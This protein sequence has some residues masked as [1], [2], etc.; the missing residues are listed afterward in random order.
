MKIYLKYDF[1][2]SQLFSVWWSVWAERVLLDLNIFSQRSQGIDTLSKCCDSMCCWMFILCP[3]FWHT[4]QMYVFR[5]PSFVRRPVFSIIDL[6]LSSS[7]CMFPMPLFDK[8]TILST[9]SSAIFLYPHLVLT[10]W[11]LLQELKLLQMDLVSQLFHSARFFVQSVLWAEIGQQVQEMIQDF[12]ERHLSLQCIE[13]QWWL[14]ALQTSHLSWRSVDERASSFSASPWRKDSMQPRS[15]CVLPPAHHPRWP[16]WH[17]LS[18]FHL[19]NFQRQCWD[20][21]WSHSTEDRVSQTFVGTDWITV[22]C[23]PDTVH[24]GEKS[25]IE[26]NENTFCKSGSSF[27]DLRWSAKSLINRVSHS[28]REKAAKRHLLFDG[29]CN[30]ILEYHL[31]PLHLVFRPLRSIINLKL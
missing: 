2:S 13:N 12:P 31:I 25:R 18:Q 28:K 22:D 23:W 1:F 24:C 30:L 5:L 27:C 11:L 10:S 29:A 21:L 26:C 4:L 14:Q 16:G 7:S 8:A 3:S 6:T 15:P 17:Q 20:C 9:S 19:W